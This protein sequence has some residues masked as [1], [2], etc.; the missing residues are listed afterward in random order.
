MNLEAIQE[1]LRTFVRER[2]WEKFHT[3][4]N[5]AMALSGEVGELVEL[6]QWLTPEESS[7]VLQDPPKAQQ[8]KHELADVFVYLLRLA[9]V[10]GVSL[11]EAVKEK[12]TVNET[13][14]PAHLARGNAKKYSELLKDE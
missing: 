10:L 7:N 1:R 8:V 4:K 11:E 13:K 9:D 2:D 5:L 14:Y 6:F 12:L 3:P